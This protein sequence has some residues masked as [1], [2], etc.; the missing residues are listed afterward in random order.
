MSRTCPSAAAKET[1]LHAHTRLK[2]IRCPLPYEKLFWIE[3]RSRRF[4]GC[5]YFAQELQL[6]LD[7]FGPHF[8]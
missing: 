8:R 2:L 6:M 3:G 1:W 7:W 4:G 5:N